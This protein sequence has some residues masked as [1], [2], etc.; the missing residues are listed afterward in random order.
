MKSSGTETGGPGDNRNE[1]FFP[2]CK[3]KRRGPAAAA[4]AARTSIQRRSERR[5]NNLGADMT[6]SVARLAPRCVSVRLIHKTQRVD[7][8]SP[9]SSFVLC[10]LP[11][12]YGTT[13]C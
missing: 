13:R 7:F 2:A 6:Q 3:R 1:A 8:I 10:F 11:S 4:A 9:A 12:K 5:V